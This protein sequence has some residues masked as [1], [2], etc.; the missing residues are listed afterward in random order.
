MPS[1][2]LLDAIKEAYASAPS[3]EVILDTIE[4]R[5]ASIMEPIYLVRNLED[6]VLTLETSVTVTFEGAAFRLS[7]PQSGENGLQEL[8][9]AVDNVDRRVSD[10]F[11]N[12]KNFQTPV[13]CVYRPY[14][15]SDHTQ[16]QMNPPLVLYLSDAQVTLFEVTAKATFADILNKKFPSRL[17]TRAGFPSLGG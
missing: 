10:F 16:P 2:T 17:Y 11:S 12:A 13:E 4:L 14:L 5:H 7:L 8:A 15:D 6:V 9:I 3:N 1:S